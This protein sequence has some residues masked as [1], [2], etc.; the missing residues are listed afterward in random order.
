M[1]FEGEYLNGKRCNGKEYDSRGNVAFEIKDGNG[2]LKEYYDSSDLI[3]EGEY[4]NG[5]KNEKGT[6][7]SG[8]GLLAFE[9]EFL[10]GKEHEKGKEYT[11]DWDYDNFSPY[12]SFE[13]GFFNGV[14]DGKRIEWIWWRL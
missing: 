14:K 7:Y 10:K 5:E 1:P 12:L 11:Y 8:N 6:F 2:Y 9:G 4:R 3:F 13:G